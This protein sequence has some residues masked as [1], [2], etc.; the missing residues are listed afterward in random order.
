[1]NA[2]FKGATFSD[3]MKTSAEAKKALLAKFKPKPTVTDPMFEQREALRLAEVERV[4][5]ER[6]AA[7]AAAREAAEAAE[8]ARLEALANDEAAQLDLKRNERKERKA[9][10]KAQARAKREQKAAARR[11]G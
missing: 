8:A 5:A 7:K 2:I 1:M 11:N 3:R 6:A 10:V 4:R 9:M